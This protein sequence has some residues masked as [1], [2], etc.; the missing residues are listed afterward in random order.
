MDR[1]CEFCGGKIPVERIKSATTCDR[2]CNQRKQSK[3]YHEAEKAFIRESDEW[4]R[5]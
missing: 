1:I 2:K 3:K 5:L 4:L